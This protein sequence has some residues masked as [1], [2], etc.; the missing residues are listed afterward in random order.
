[1]REPTRD[2]A[3]PGVAEALPRTLDRLATRVGVTALDTL[4]IFPPLVRGRREWGLVVASCFVEDAERRRLVTAR[5]HAQRTGRGL[6]MEAEITEQGDAPPDRFPRIVDGVGH[7]SGVELGEPAEVA[8]GG[9]AQAFR[10]LMGGFDPAL[11]ETA[12]P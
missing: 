6:E 5:Y 1:M 7:R 11:L 3:G 10:A 2:D 12:E 9:D 4:W 8:V